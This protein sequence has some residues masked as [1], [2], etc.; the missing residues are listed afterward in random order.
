MIINPWGKVLARA[1]TNDYNV[2]KEFPGEIIKA[3]L[4]KKT[5]VDFRK[6]VPCLENAKLLK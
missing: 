6:S 2:K 3:K 1:S 5:L 4:D